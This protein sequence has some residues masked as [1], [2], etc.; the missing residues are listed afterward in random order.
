MFI[1]WVARVDT[2]PHRYH[3]IILTIVGDGWGVVVVAGSSLPCLLKVAT[4]A[5]SL[6]LVDG[7]V[8]SSLLFFLSVSMWLL[9]VSRRRR[10]N[11]NAIKCPANA[12]KLPLLRF[13]ASCSGTSRIR[14]HWA[15]TTNDGEEEDEDEDGANVIQSDGTGITGQEGQEIGS[16]LKCHCERSKRWLNLLMHPRRFLAQEEEDGN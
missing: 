14:T 12:N 15:T 16:Q 13:V 2:L 10:M 1:E 4:H 9:T 5:W 3:R 7:G 6:F 11:W 8:S